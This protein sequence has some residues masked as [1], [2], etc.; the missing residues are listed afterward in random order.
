M[1]THNDSLSSFMQTFESS[2]GNGILPDKTEKAKVK[3]YAKQENL[4]N[5]SAHLCT[6]L[7]LKFLKN[8]SYRYLVKINILY[9]KQFGFRERHSTRGSLPNFTFNI[10]LI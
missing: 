3:V 8:K 2:Q 10:K 9:K 5:L 4:I 6:N 1:D 7:S